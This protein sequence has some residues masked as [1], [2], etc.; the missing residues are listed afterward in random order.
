MAYPQLFTPGRI[1]SV[2]IPNRVVMPAIGTVL[3]HADG[4]VS[5]DQIAYYEERARGG[6]GLIV[7]EILAVENELGRAVSVQTRV[8]D[9]RFIPGLTRLASTIRQYPTRLFGQLHHAGNQ[10]NSQ[11]TGG[12]QIVA[13]SA[14][15]NEAVGEEPR[16]LSGEEVKELVAKFVAAAVRCQIA[17]FD[18]VQLHGAHGYLINQFLSPRSNRREDEYGGSLENRLR[19]ITQ[20]VQGIRDRCGDGFPVMVRYSADEFVVGGITLDEGLAIARHLESIGVA[21]LDV[22]CGTYESM[23]TLL[24]PITYAQGWRVYLAEAVRAEVEIPV[25]TVG[26]IRQPAYA[27]QV[28]AQ[29]KAD[30]VAIGRGL[31]SDAQWAR[32][33]REGR[34]TQI[35][36]CISCLRCVETIFVGRPIE[37]AVNARTGREHWVP[38]ELP[39]D[40]DGRKVA[41]VGGGP[42]GME[43]ARVL[44]LRGYAPV[45]FEKEKE[46]GG[47]LVPG[48]MPP[49]KEQIAWY[50]DYLIGELD[51]LGVET[52]LQTQAT[53]ATVGDEKP[54]AVLVA[55]GAVPVVPSNIPGIPGEGVCSFLDVLRGDR[56]AADGQSVI[57]VG[58]GLTGCETAHLLATQGARVTVLEMLG[59]I[60]ESEHPATRVGIQEKLDKAEVRVLTG[61]KVRAIRDG[62]VEIEHVEE[63]GEETLPADL[64]VLAMGLKVDPEQV[65]RWLEAFPDA[66]VIG[67][68]VAPRKVAEA[69]REGFDAAHVLP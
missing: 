24:E 27:E 13:P 11:I 32:K 33:A 2:T 19:F 57:V 52:R 36:Q 23:Q 39:R 42:G 6:T 46:L 17:G 66:R 8:D 35:C 18:G 15:T 69:V 50:K 9:D 53:P 58:A 5:E 43:A 14:V 20:I 45:I 67:D 37:C 26:V 62:D 30:F 54:H 28:L 16:A 4:S 21:A 38:A 61:R 34:D 29:G 63:G 31:L 68:A 59:G 55:V 56:H 49:G 48:C 60:A 44:A 64:V 41:I 65:T 3:C 1:G 40:G 12:K 25:V 47:Q 10:S 51:R 22:S 7:T